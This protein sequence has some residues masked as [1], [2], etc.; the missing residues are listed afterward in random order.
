MP[1][2]ALLFDLDDTLL[3]TYP[4]HRAAIRA[5]C[6]RAA[7]KHP[8]RTPEELQRAFLRAYHDLEAKVEAGTLQ[9]ATVMLFRTRAWE[10][11]LASVDLPPELAQ[12][13]ATLYRD[14]RARRYRLYP[15]VGDLL[16][17]LASRY[18]LVLVTNGPG[19]LQREKIAAVQLERWIERIVISGEVGSWK[20]HPAIFQ[21]ALE[22]AGAAP[23]EAVMLGDSLERDIRGARGLGIRTVWVRRYEHLKPVSGLQPDRTVRDLRGLPELLADWD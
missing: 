19:D 18:C 15:E 7:E 12:D 17:Q 22:M 13:L 10:E 16:E 20:P 23:D 1:I 14:E 8:G 4:A 2:R 9:F 21:R 11:T 6:E 3:E 5:T